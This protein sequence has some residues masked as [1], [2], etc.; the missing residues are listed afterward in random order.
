MRTTPYDEIKNKLSFVLPADLLTYLPDKWEKI[1]SV[2]TIKIPDALMEYKKIIGKT[3][4]EILH[5]R[6][7]LNDHGE[8][9]G[10]YRKPEV[11]II[12]GEKTTETI[13]TENGIRFKLDP[14]QIM[15]SSGNMAERKR[16]ATISNSQEIII[17]L[18]AGIGYFTL[19]L[20]VYSKP[21]KIFACEI[22]PLA[23]QY[24]C[25]N[26]A[27][28]HVTDIVEPR[29][30]DNRNVA[31][32]QCADRVILGYLH[33]PWVFLPTAMECLRNYSGILHYHEVVP[34]ESIPEQPFQRIQTIAKTYHRTVELL[35][36]TI[37]KSY[38][39]CL[40]HIVLDVELTP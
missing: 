39:P 28:N 26:I 10:V 16:M 36:A 22:N 23:Y 4:C 31:P 30:G 34:F 2:V 20:A 38:A 21:K 17:D 29:C 6:T 9:F 25:S 3:Y 18:F 11:D 14:Q 37:I 8:I 24:L 15:F 40:D 33:E 7:A 19:P 32:K 27:L 35:Q 13:H 5:A 12:S 1:G